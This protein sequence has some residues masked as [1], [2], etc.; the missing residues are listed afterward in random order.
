MEL[1][2]VKSSNIAEIGHEGTTLHVRFRGGNKT[3]VYEG[4]PA[5]VHAELMASE[6]V[7]RHFAQVIK[8]RYPHKVV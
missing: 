5:D 7:G 3:Y 8:G 2:P 4:V 1:K 6:S